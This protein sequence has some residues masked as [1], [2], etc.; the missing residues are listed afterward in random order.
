MPK[1]NDTALAIML[2]GAYLPP[3]TLVEYVYAGAESWII[4]V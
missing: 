4:N 2:I 3:W 1:M